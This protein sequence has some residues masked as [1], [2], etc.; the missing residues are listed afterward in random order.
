MPETSHIKTLVMMADGKPVLTLLRGDHLLNETKLEALLEAQE[1]RPAHPEELQTLMGAD[2][3]SL[4][5]VN[6]PKDVEIL[7][8]LALKDRKN[9]ICGANANDKHLR[10]VT[11]GRDFSPRFEDL[12]LIE[13]GDLDVESGEPVR[14]RKCIEIGHIFKLGYRYSESM[15]LRVL[16]ANGKETTP[17]MGS[18]GIGME[19]I[20]TAAI[21]Q[22][23][24][25]TGMVLP[26]SIAPFQVVVTPVNLKDETQANAAEGLYADCQKLGI[27]VLFD[28][29]AER[30]G[31]KFK[32]AD[33]IGV[34][35][36]IV[37]GKGISD[38]IVEFVDR[39]SGETSDVKLSDVVDLLQDKLGTP[40]S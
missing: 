20:L 36:R 21:E 17:I 27:D 33:L 19:R 24:S 30:A 16:D 14:L 5:P 2:A 40:A 26:A 38:G 12:R 39:S 7:A 34:P 6:A 31:V 35:Y 15:N 37:V 8:D 11:P 18:Y 23:N 32:D 25:E 9:L 13:D 28:D 1:L 22:N 10:N 4:G 3:G 29:R